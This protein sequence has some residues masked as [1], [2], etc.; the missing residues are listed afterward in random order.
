MNNEI[1]IM[2]NGDIPKYTLCF[3]DG[4][5]TAKNKTK[6][7]Q[8]VKLLFKIILAVLII[9]SI[10]F[11][12]FLL[13]GSS[14][15]VW[16]CLFIVIGYLLKNG[17]YERRAFPAELRFYEDYMIFYVPSYILDNKN[18][19]QIQKMY[20]KDVTSC[21]FRRNTRKMV[22]SGT[23][24]EVHYTYDKK[25]QLGTKP[26]YKKR[27]DGMIKFYT[28][29]DVEHDFKEIIEKNSPL[30]VEFENL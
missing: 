25:G 24:D 17:G 4:R 23:L 27:Y 12:E 8:I 20:Y 7:Y 15:S 26:S 5:M 1:S 2:N 3:N 28:V 11:G 9:G 21:V 10:I 29:F 22:I 19:M 13:N 18:E 14:L 6:A 16:I 30:V